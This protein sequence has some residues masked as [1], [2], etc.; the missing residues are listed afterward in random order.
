MEGAALSVAARH[1]KV[2]WILVKAICDWA[3]GNKSQ[4]KEQRQKKAALNAVLF[5]IHVLKQGGFTA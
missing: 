3:D 5:T 4:S 1:Y 2:D